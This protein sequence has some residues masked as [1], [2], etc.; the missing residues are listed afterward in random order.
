[1]TLQLIIA[2]I[3]EQTTDIKSFILRAEDSSELPAFEA[4][5]HINVAVKLPD[6]SKSTRSYS[7]ANSQQE[8]SYYELGI[9]RQG[10]S[11]GSSYIHQN[12]TIGTHVEVSKPVN[13]FRLVEG[14]D[15]EHIL[16]AGG[17]GVTPM[18][19]MARTLNEQG[20]GFEFH[21]FGR[22]AENLAFRDAIAKLPN[23]Q[24]SEYLGADREQVLQ[25]LRTITQH[26]AP[27]R[28]LYVCGPTGMIQSVLEA[29][30]A[31]G[32]LSEHVHYEQFSGGVVGLDNRAFTVELALSK[33]TLE[34]RADQTLLDAL[35][36]AKVEAY[37]DCRSGVCGS[38]LIP[39]CSG[40]VDHRDTF[41]SDDE[42]TESSL[43]CSC[44][45]RA[46]GASLVLD[47]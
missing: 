40:E 4:G 9:L 36:E 3:V 16:I 44:V 31:S 35:L 15:I 39:V 27:N 12:L 7:I 10:T 47:I 26:P 30:Q 33:K 20:R 6:G 43:I 38:C 8:C 28:H 23:E 37:F 5:A 21:Y 1:M 22:S 19:S 24:V 45:S 25:L 41:L 11:G 2:D 13:N 14:Q 17:I 34:V 29:A 46:R 18:L 32:W 42:K